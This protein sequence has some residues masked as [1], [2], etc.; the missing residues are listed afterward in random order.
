MALNRNEYST[1]MFIK[2]FLFKKSYIRKSGRHSTKA[3][4]NRFDEMD[5]R[6]FT[7]TM[8]ASICFRYLIM[9]TKLLQ[10]VSGDCVES[11]N[12][13]VPGPHLFATILVRDIFP[14]QS[15]VLARQ[16]ISIRS[17]QHT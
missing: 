6:N 7:L 17:R 15:P 8:S 4:N 13:I 11:L 1:I 10:S 5:Y 12:P 16:L 2:V 9:A 3:E 14:F